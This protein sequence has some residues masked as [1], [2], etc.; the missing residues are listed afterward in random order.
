MPRW[1][2]G[3]EGRGGA[4]RKGGG[5]SA[6]PAGESRGERR[7]KSCLRHARRA[8]VV[9]RDGPAP[10]RESPG[11]GSPTGSEAQGVART[12]DVINMRTSVRGGVEGETERLRWR[13]LEGEP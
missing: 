8:C 2:G 9:A 5:H 1:A 13:S 12:N 3:G 4:G 7:R 6:P 11:L 10:L